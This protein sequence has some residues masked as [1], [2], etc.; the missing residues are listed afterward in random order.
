[1]KRKIFLFFCIFTIAVTSAFGQKISKPTLTPKPVTDSQ[2]KLIQEGIASHDAKKYDEAIAKYEAVLSENPD[3]T[4]A[5]Y[6]LALT[7]YTK[8]D[9]DKALEAA[10]RGSKYKSPELALFYG[11][12]ANIIDDRGKPKEAIK[13]YQ[14]AIKILENEPDANSQLASIH[15]NLG[16]TYVRQKMYTEARGEL[17]KAVEFNPGYASPHYL[18]SEVFYGS[19]YKVPSMLAASRFLSLEYATQRSDRAVSLILAVMAP[20]KKDPKTGNTTINLDFMAPE[21]EGSYAMYDLLIPTLGMVDDEKNKESQKPKTEEEKFADGME[22][23]ISMLSEDEKLKKT[24]VG[25]HYV[26]FFAE[27][28]AKGYVKMFS[29]IIL[30]KSGNKNVGA[31]IDGQ[32]PKLQEFLDWA[33]AYRPSTK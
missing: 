28:K 23:V 18:L 4:L 32:G 12:I 29:Y 31:W 19:K 9:K 22:T 16:V 20:A 17:K 14:D 15:Y 6:E 11:T 27:M 7:Q 33:K 26:P 24:F 21:D 8:G 1:M 13:I 5:I 2:R 10:L 30:F 25:K 3:A